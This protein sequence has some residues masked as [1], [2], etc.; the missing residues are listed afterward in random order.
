MSKSAARGPS[1]ARDKKLLARYHDNVRLAR[2][3]GAWFVRCC[4]ARDAGRGAE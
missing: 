4:Q 1:A 2:A 3:L